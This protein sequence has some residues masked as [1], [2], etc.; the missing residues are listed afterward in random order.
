MGNEINRILKQFAALQHGNHWTDNSFKQVLHGVDAEKAMKAIEGKTNSIWMLVSHIIY[1][2]TYVANRLTASNNPP[3]FTDFKL[4]SEINSNTWH[5]ALQDFESVYHLLRNAIH[6]FNEDNLDK[7][8]PKKDQT[9]YELIIG[10]LQHD[11]Y[12]LGQMMLIKK[13]CA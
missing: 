12:H 13:V 11:V 5:Q 7:P 3:P 9:Y 6:H 1:W 8:S 2:R 4:P 10:C